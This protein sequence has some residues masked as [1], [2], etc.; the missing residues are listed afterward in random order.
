MEKLFLPSDWLLG[1]TGATVASNLGPTE[2]M[3]KF[4]VG[5]GVSVLVKPVSVEFSTVP[6]ELIPF[7]APVD[8]TISITMQY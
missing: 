4:S 6:L 2:T 5:G 7:L 1:M 3:V 8:Q